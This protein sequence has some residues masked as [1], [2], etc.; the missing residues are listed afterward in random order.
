MSDCSA[1]LMQNPDGRHEMSSAYGKF[2]NIVETP[3]EDRNDAT[4]RDAIEE[5]RDKI[6]K[7][8]LKPLTKLPCQAHKLV[9]KEIDKKNNSA[10]IGLT[11]T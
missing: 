3:V 5:M 6:D 4:T 1:V 7:L 10:C 11:D 8:S 9:Q 2:C